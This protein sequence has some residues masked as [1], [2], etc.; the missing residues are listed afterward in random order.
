LWNWKKILDNLSSCDIIEKKGGAFMSQ[1]LEQANTNTR[2][3][4]AENG[5][6][7]KIKAA[8]IT[9]SGYVLAAIIGLLAVIFGRSASEANQINIEIQNA[10]HQAQQEDPENAAL[11][12][13]VAEMAQLIEQP[14]TTRATLE[15]Q[16]A[17]IT[18]LGN[19]TNIGDSMSRATANR[20]NYRNEYVAEVLYFER[21]DGANLEFHALLDGQYSRLRGTVFVGYGQT[22]SGES[23]F[24]FELDGRTVESHTMDRTSRP[25]TI[26]I[27]LTNVNEFKIVRP[28]SSFYVHFA[29]FQFYP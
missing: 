16:A 6:G 17:S 25:I 29:D 20:D 14:A 15:G 7:T 21:W 12:N 28:G 19:M 3:H 18:S 8:L 24:R 11:R 27:D 10:V 13:L 2:Q 4:G 22:S 1:K 26:D 5:G 23:H 9:A